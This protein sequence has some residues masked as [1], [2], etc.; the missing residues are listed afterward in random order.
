M[1]IKKAI[2]LIALTLVIAIF[3]AGC[4]FPSNVPVQ[5]NTE[6]ASGEETNGTGE[7]TS[8]TTMNISIDLIGPQIGTFV[9][10]ADNSE[11]VFVPGGEFVMG[12]DGNDNPQRVITLSPFWIQRTE[13]TNAMYSVCVATGKCLPPE[14]EQSLADLSNSLKQEYPVTG[15]SWEQAAAY[16]EWI[17][18][19][20]PTEAE[21]EKTARGEEGNIFPWGDGEASCD[22]ANYGTCLNETSKVRTHLEG[23]SFYEVLGLAGNVAEWVLDW[24]DPLY[25]E[26]APEFDP[27]GPASGVE[28]VYRGG[29][30]AS[31]DYHLPS[32]VR[33]SDDPQKARADI[34]FRCVVQDVTPRAPYC[35]TSQ[36]IPSSYIP[37]YSNPE[38]PYPKS[39]TPQTG[40]G[41]SYGYI[42]FETNVDGIE[43][44]GGLDCEVIDNRVRC[45]GPSATEQKVVVCREGVEVPVDISSL[46]TTGGT[47]A[48]G[49]VSDFSNYSCQFDSF[50]PSSCDGGVCI[51]PTYGE[52]GEAPLCPY[53]TYFD[54]LAEMCF[55]G[56]E[57][58]TTC[59][60]GFEYDAS[61]GCCTSPTN[62]YPG[63]RPGEFA[64][65]VGCIP[66]MNSGDTT[67]VPS[68]CEEVVITTGICVAETEEPEPE[69]PSGDSGGSGMACPVG[70][71]LYCYYDTFLGRDVCS[72]I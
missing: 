8:N 21:W 58:G 18:G 51:E 27:Q 59:L 71:T 34:G 9:V 56:D 38:Y 66:Y 70:Q 57:P 20:L 67:T 48:S 50:P 3:V 24:Y 62:T 61:N 30:F 32:A 54:T 35:V 1:F 68:G 10:W 15:V 44:S 72:C 43:T 33:F 63:C 5:E 60:A 65:S 17:E 19:R 29:G 7:P 69:E 53:G 14:N 45:S 36:Y 46:P 11:L 40:S 42:D 49:Y 2:H 28:R 22:L 37:E 4:T 55:G 64:S 26:N 16:C 31:P 23:K 52:D 13:V 39:T 41:C 12:A 47:C 6:N 25:Y